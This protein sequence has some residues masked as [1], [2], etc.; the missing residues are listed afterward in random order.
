MSERPYGSLVLPSKGLL[1]DGKLP[2]GVIEI[3]DWDTSI[4]EIFAGVVTSINL[5]VDSILKRTIKTP[6]ITPGELLLGDRFFIF[7]HSRSKA[8]G[9]SYGF[10]FKCQ[11][12]N[13]QYRHRISIPDDLEIVELPEDASEPFYV[14]LPVSGD[15]VGFRLLRGKDED[16]VEKY[17]AKVYKKGTPEGDPAFRYRLARHI[18]SVNNKELNSTEALDYVKN[19]LSK[20]SLVF[21]NK[22]DSIEPRLDTDITVTCKRCGTDNE[23]T[24]PFSKDFLRPRDID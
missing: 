11:S 5:L 22:I 4:E 19:M 10:S 21:R 15:E 3:Y 13:V 14:S 20:D 1:Y 24:L 23:I 7:F 18:V 8:Y 6:S 2:G 9:S 12:C 16:A 17:Q